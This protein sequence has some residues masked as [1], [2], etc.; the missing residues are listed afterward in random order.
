[1]VTKSRRIY[2]RGYK[3]ANNYEMVMQIFYFRCV[4]LKGRNVPI[5]LTRACMCEH[6]K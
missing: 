1:M 5:Q 6:K 2:A 3:F 4:M